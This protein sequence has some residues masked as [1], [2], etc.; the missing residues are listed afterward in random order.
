M[1]V[2]TMQ[3]LESMEKPDFPVDVVLRLNGTSHMSHAALNKWHEAKLLA[4]WAIEDGFTVEI[5]EADKYCD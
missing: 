4:K 2:S 3:E 5:E 1:F